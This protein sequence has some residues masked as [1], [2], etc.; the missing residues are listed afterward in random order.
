VAA[1]LAFSPGAKAFYVVEALG[2]DHSPPLL[3]EVIEVSPLEDR[4]AT[5][6][7]VAA[8]KDPINVTYDARANRLLIFQSA[9]NRLIEVREGPGGNLD[10]SPVYR[11]DARR[12]GLQNPQGM[13]VDPASGHLYILDAAGPRIVRIEPNPEGGFDGAVI[14]EIDLGLAD[15]DD[16]RGL[17][18]EPANGHFYVA[19][20]AEQELYELTATGQVVTTRSLSGFGL[21][22]PQ[23]LVSA[24]SGDLTD[25]LSQMSLY[26]A[27]S[28][29]V[30][31][32]TLE[33][34]T[35]DS[36][37]DATAADGPQGSEGNITEL[38]FTP[39]PEAAAATFVSGLVHTTDTSQW[40]PPSPDSAGI[41]YHSG[42]NRLIVSDSEV[43]EMSVYEGVN[44]FETTLAGAVHETGTTLDS[45]ASSE[46]HRQSIRSD[47][48][49]GAGLG[50]YGRC[51]REGIH[52]RDGP[53]QQR[54]RAD[55]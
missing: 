51:G 34:S 45:S 53:H 5:A 48:P 23:G 42:R 24:P 21:V 31:Q 12:F 9:S 54:S 15:M 14:S 37:Q 41:T 11:H 8:I 10:P 3:L 43:N 22:D 25:D 30:S 35:A 47:H 26:I 2:P 20:P 29:Q 44:L 7:V 19:S 16:A 50:Q 40:S 1:G 38:S 6:R 46:H 28:G 49:R 13:A 36:I 39:V 33:T 4:G 17:A 55:H 32:Q 18:L 27:D 52:W